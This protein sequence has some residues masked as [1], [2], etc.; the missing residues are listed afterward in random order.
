MARCSQNQNL[1]PPEEPNKAIKNTI[2]NIKKQSI[3]LLKKKNVFKA[4]Q[5]YDVYY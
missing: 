5:I 4:Q 1:L 3:N 2:F